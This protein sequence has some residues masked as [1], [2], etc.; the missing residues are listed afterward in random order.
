MTPVAKLTPADLLSL[1]DYHR[2]RPAF[3]R[4]LIA[5]KKRR[6]LDIGPHAHLYFEN[7]L[8]M[9]YQV[10]EMLRAEK[11]FD[12]EGIAGELAAY[13]PLIPDGD[14]FKATMMLQYVDAAERR[15]ALVR[16]VGI[17]E[18]VWQRVGRFDPQYAIADEDAERA[19]D[20]KT[21]AVHF[22]RFQLDPARCEALKSGAPLAIGI[23]HPEY[24]HT[25]DPLDETLAR[26]LRD[27]L[28]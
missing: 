2:E 3:R 19:T 15:A 27:D 13:N 4:Q 14:N 10:Q 11:I 28:D 23:D 20:E 5:E 21:S 12:P 24:S 25:I 26:A 1:E 16:L 17:E 8:T 22:L 18:R 7:L 9:R 6:R